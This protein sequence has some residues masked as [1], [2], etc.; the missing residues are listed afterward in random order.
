MKIIAT[1]LLV[2][3]LSG[4]AL[5]GTIHLPS[6][7]FKF[8]G[9]PLSDTGIYSFCFRGTQFLAIRSGQGAQLR[10]VQ[11]MALSARILHENGTDSEGGGAMECLK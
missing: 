5:A 4:S 1:V 6:G 2:L 3:L 9:R 10:V 8:F 7:E 11:V